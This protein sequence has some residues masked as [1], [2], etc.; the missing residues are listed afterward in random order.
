M[1]ALLLASRE[2]RQLPVAEMRQSDL[3]ERG[4]DQ[5]PRAG[6]AGVACAHMDDLLNR[7]REGD[8]DMLRQHRAVM[9]EFA[10]RIAADFALLQFDMAR[11]RA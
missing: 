6:A 5:P 8:G 9:G 4:I 2:R 11:R 1:C 3:A 10:R 7:E